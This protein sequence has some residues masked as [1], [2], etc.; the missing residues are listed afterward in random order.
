MS[1]SIVVFLIT[2][3]PVS[4]LIKPAVPEWVIFKSESVPKA[5]LWSSAII[6]LLAPDVLP[7]ANTALN[8]GV[9]GIVGIL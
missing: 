5:T 9:P 4:L 6:I 3:F 7:T 8:A 1:V 2:K